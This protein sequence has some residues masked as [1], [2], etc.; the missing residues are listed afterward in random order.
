MRGRDGML[1]ALSYLLRLT[2][3]PPQ[4]GEFLLDRPNKQDR[5]QKLGVPIKIVRRAENSA[6]DGAELISP[7]PSPKTRNTPQPPLALPPA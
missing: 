4:F 5:E 3:L 1:E 6:A 2:C 7:R